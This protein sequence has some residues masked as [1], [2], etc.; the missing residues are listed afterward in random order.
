DPPFGPGTA[1]LHDGVDCWLD[2]V[3]VDGNLQLHFAQQVDS[4]LMTAINLAVSLLPAKTLYVDN[5]QPK[6]GDSVE[7]L[8]DGLKLRRLNDRE[9]ELHGLL[10]TRSL[11]ALAR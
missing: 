8:L 5:R 3:F 7:R 4:Q 10:S 2:E 9:D 6:Y 11:A 1:R